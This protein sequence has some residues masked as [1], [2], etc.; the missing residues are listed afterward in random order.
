[1]Y[2]CLDNEDWRFV[3]CAHLRHA[4]AGRRNRAYQRRKRRRGLVMQRYE[5]QG[6]ESVWLLLFQ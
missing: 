3:R 6:E 1:M 4:Q 5:R 2:Y